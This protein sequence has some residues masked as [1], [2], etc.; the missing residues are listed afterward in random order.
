[1]SSVRS[2]L[3]A[4]VRDVYGRS[5]EPGDDIFS[6]EGTSLQAIDLIARFETIVGRTIA[7]ERLVAS[8]SIVH[9]ISELGEEARY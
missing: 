3:E 5:P 1:M 8:E 9:L 7:I 4:A 6:L 2:E